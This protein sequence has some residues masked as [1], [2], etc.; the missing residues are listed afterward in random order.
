MK[1]FLG[2][3]NDAVVAV[4]DGDEFVDPTGG[5]EGGVGPGQVNQ[6]GRLGQ[7]QEPGKKTFQRAALRVGV[8]RDDDLGGE[9][10]EA[11]TQRRDHH[12]RIGRLSGFADNP[13]KQGLV[14]KPE[15][16]LGALHP[17]ALAAAKDDRGRGFSRV[18]H[19]RDPFTEGPSAGE[20]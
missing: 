8:T 11:L 18:G 9:G 16:R 6:F 13:L 7:G 15:P 4:G 1:K 14:A 20:S 12:D 3:D 10:R 19:A 2:V 5:K 17:T